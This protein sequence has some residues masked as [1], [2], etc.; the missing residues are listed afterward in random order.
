VPTVRGEERNAP[1]PI[2]PALCVGD[3]GLSRFKSPW[4]DVLGVGVQ[5]KNPIT[6]KPRSL[7]AF[8][9]FFP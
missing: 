6:N 3:W 7:E 5:E 2:L 9:K 4:R 8:E 1:E